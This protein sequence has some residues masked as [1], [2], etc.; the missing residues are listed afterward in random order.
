[1]NSYGG[2]LESFPEWTVNRPVS[3]TVY[4]KAYGVVV[5]GAAFAGSYRG[6]AT[7]VSTQLRSVQRLAIPYHSRVCRRAVFCFFEGVGKSLWGGSGGRC[8]SYFLSVF[9]PGSEGF[10]CESTV[11]AGKNK[12][13]LS[14]WWNTHRF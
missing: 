14:R 7:I 11:T 1:M 4:S 10:E 3:E 6:R 12:S 8:K 13:F 5:S 9:E 2:H